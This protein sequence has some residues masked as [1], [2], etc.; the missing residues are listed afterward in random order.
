MKYL[1]KINNKKLNNKI[2]LLRVDFNINF[3]KNNFKIDAILPT[4]KF[5][6][7]K[8]SKVVI[9]SH[10]GR[11]SNGKDKKLSLN[12]IAKIISKE[13]KTNVKFFPN[14]NFNEIK[15][16]IISDKNSKIFLLENL[17]FLSGEKNNDSKLAKELAG[18]GD[19]YINDAFAVCH[20]KNAST[21]AITK[22]IESYVGLL[23]EKEI[24]GLIK[25]IKIPKKPLVIILGGSKIDKK[26]DIIK[27]LNK[28]TFKF[29]LGSSIFNKLTNL[30]IKELQKNK[31]IILPIDF[32]KKNEK[33]FDIGPKTI[34]YYE[35]I[36][37]EANTIIW[38]G[39]IG[40]IEKKEYSNGS[41]QI[42]LAISKSK[43]FKV[44][45]GGETVN[46]ILD[47]KIQKKISF[48]STGGGAML[49]FLAGKKLPG[50][51]A[52]KSSNIKIKKLDKKHR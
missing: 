8:K 44:I 4:I 16:K 14:F 51:T 25:A 29:L 21:V 3:S 2:C 7:S 49:D 45:G 27:N 39:P 15:E 22:Y 20:R 18:L 36:I 9:L 34:K 6:I 38:N 46:F 41:K 50:I 33:Y 19:I 37:K 13:L 28:K 35:K 40:M 11:P 31:K 43:A 32:V 1:S 5:L 17:R 47:K 30:K 26:I 24:N 23:L 42:A 52:L 12:Y 48:L 10:R